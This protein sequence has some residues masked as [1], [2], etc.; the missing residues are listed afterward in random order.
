MSDAIIILCAFAS[1]EDA[2]NAGR[3]LLNK[4]LIACAHVFAAGQSQY[5]WKDKI[6]STSENYAIFKTT[7]DKFKDVESVIKDMHGYDVP[8]IVAL[9]VDAGHQPFL[10]WIAAQTA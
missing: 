10:D 2:N 1:A 7:R 9:S 6:E 5:W 8:C 3:A 4:R